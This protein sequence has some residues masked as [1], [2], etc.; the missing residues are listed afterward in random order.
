MSD[1]SLPESEN[2]HGCHLG[3]TGKDEGES[4]SDDN[5]APDQS[6]RSSIHQAKVQKPVCIR[7]SLGPSTSPSVPPKDGPFSGGASEGGVL[8]L[9]DQMSAPELPPGMPPGEP[10]PMGII[11]SAQV[12]SFHFEQG[13]YWFRIQATHIAGHSPKSV[14]PA[15]SLPASSR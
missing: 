6:G 14:R 8:P 13:D 10:L 12:D 11:T 15:S 5:E 4:R 9:A 1:K 7:Q 2:L 3:Y